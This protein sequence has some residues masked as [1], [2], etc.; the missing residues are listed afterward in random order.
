MSFA[1]QERMFP[2]ANIY[3][4]LIQYRNRAKIYTDKSLFPSRHSLYSS[5]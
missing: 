5:C 3:K 1:L 4:N 2:Y